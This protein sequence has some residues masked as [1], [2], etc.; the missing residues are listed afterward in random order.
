MDTLGVVNTPSKPL[1]ILI[2][3]DDPV[4]AGLHRDAAE[5]IGATA[6][7]CTT[8]AEATQ[9]A[10]AQAHD[11]VVLDRVLE[12]GESRD[13]LSLIHALDEMELTPAFLVVSALSGARHRIEG[14]NRGADDYLA[15]PFEVEELQ[16][17]L[18]ALARRIGARGASATILTAGRLELRRLTRSVHWQGKAIPVSEQGFDILIVLA[19]RNGGVASRDALWREVWRDFPNLPPQPNVI[20]AAIRRLRV[21]LVEVMGRDPIATVRRQGYRLDA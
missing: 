1:R 7:L 17:R 3:E 15:K 13:G 21:A 5:A 20:E 19:E 2:V 16:A 11:I 8:L 9:A 14:L 6:T 10:R 12:G 4:F 18:L